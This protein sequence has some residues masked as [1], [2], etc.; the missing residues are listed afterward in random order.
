MKSFFSSLKPALIALT[1][2]T[3]L[4]GVVYPLF[5]Y[6]VGQL[7]F[8]E[9]ANGSLFYYQN[10][11]V[12]GSEWI[13]QNFTKP[14]YF[15]PRPSSAGN[16]YDA[17]NSSGSNLGPTAQ[18]LSDALTQRA[19]AYRKEN[20]LAADTPL[21]A[22]SVTASASGLDPHIGKQNAMLQASRVASARDLPV[23][24]VYALIEEYTEG[25]TWGLLGEARIN[26]LR[27]NLALDKLEGA[28]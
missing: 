2:L 17:S 23:E 10:G 24:R 9:K 16:G 14:E 27:I 6:G 7:F 12:I 8:R 3:L 19:Q 20:G 22:D 11:Q 5:M 13:G 21:P 1:L 28:E 25:A 15:H 18:K 4:L 26:V